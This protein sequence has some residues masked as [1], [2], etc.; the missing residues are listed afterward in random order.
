MARLFDN[1]GSGDAIPVVNRSA[2]PDTS[3]VQVADWSV[4]A[5]VDGQRSISDI[6]QQLPLKEGEVVDSLRRLRDLG[7]IVLPAVETRGFQA[8]G[9]SSIRPR[10]GVQRGAPEKKAPEKKVPKT[11]VA[12]DWP[13]GWPLPVEQFLF[14]PLE[15]DQEVEIDLEKRKQI[16][17][18]H[19][20]LQRVTFYDLF[21][22]PRVADAR[23]LR[24]AYFKLS[25]EFHPDLY[26]RKELGSFRRKVEEIFQW[27]SK[28]YALLTD[29]GQRKEYDALLDRGLLGPWQ[30]PQGSAAGGGGGQ[31]R[32]PAST[33]PPQPPPQT[34]PRGPMPSAAE[35]M[36]VAQAA[37]AAGQWERALALY[38]KRLQAGFDT[39]AAHRAARCLLEMDKGLAQAELL[40]RQA[41]DVL[42]EPR[43]RIEVLLTLAEI[44]EQG[45]RHID[46]RDCYGETLRLDPGHQVAKMQFDR[47][48]GI[49]A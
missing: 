39:V 20:H 38:R 44:F 14:D 37:E 7:M 26:F 17:Y 48:S 23:G 36:R 47:L 2:Q 43:Q 27:L 49:K 8:Q 21:Q 15:L 11:A 46:A 28:A 4:L 5:R 9:G 35:L 30:L 45:G 25:K 29:D 24:K 12:V 1:L 34:P 32:G 31:R 6:I 10:S 22:V 42:R 41:L 3:R 40:C 16:L 33:P 19:Y 18:Y 13:Q